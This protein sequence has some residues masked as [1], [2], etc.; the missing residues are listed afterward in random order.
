MENVLGRQWVCLVPSEPNQEPEN[1][2]SYLPIY[3]RRE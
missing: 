2:V 1:S 3:A